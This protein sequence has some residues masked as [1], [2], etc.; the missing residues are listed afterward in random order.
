MDGIISRAFILIEEK[1]VLARLPCCRHRAERAVGAVPSLPAVTLR[2][3]AIPTLH[4]GKGSRNIAKLAVAACS[5]TRVFR[6]PAVAYF[7]TAGFAPFIS[8]PSFTFAA[9][10]AKSGPPISHASEWVVI[11]SNTHVRAHTHTRTAF[12][13]FLPSSNPEHQSFQRLD[14]TPLPRNLQRCAVKYHM[15]ANLAVQYHNN[16]S[17][18]PF[19]DNVTRS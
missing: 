10:H 14:V 19:L 13:S 12:S 6:P 15:T 3:S 17:L 11:T 5:G 4:M 16:V 7:E 2:G 1:A 9:L 8:T 18:Q